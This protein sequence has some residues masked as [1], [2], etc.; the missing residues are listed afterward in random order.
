[1][2]IINTGLFYFGTSG[3]SYHGKIKLSQREFDYAIH[4]ILKNRAVKKEINGAGKYPYLSKNKLKEDMDRCE[5]D[6]APCK[7]SLGVSVNDYITNLYKNQSRYHY[8]RQNYIIEI[9]K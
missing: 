9:T 7:Y 3:T 8:K 6:C 5:R 2:K 1:M 4:H